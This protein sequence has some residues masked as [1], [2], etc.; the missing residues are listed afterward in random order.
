MD[1]PSEATYLVMTKESRT[2]KLMR[3]LCYVDYVLKS[4]WL[5]ES[6]KVGKFLPPETYKVDFVLA[7]ENLKFNLDTVLLS[8]NR[9]SLFSGK[10]FYVTP[11]VF[12]SQMEI[13]HM[14]ESCGGKV[15]EKR[16]SYQTIV[17]THNQSPD[18][19]IIVTCSNDMHLCVDLIRFGSPKCPIVTTEFV[20]SSI[21]KQKLEIESNLIP[22]LYKT[23]PIHNTSYG[24]NHAWYITN[25]NK[26]NK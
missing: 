2:C 23:H 14:I 16:R 4:L 15:E 6:A 7:N 25:T 20:M 5:V 13:I 24:R 8:N 12:P 1:D 10:Y 17:D 11:D 19:Y 9:N 22:Y 3:A 18:S 26:Y 21:L